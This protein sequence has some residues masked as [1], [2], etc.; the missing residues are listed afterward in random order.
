MEDADIC[1]MA[2]TVEYDRDAALD[3]AM[4]LFWVKGD[5]ATSLKDLENA[6]QMRPGSIYAAFRSKEALF[7]EALDQYATR[8]AADLRKRI[9]AAAS[10]LGALADY[11][12][13]LSDLA[14][15]DR[16]STACMLVKSVLELPAN[17]EIRNVVVAHLGEIE[18]QLVHALGRAVEKSELPANTD[19]ARIAR[20][21]QTY[22]FG[23]KIQAQR[24][25]NADHMRELCGDLAAD[26]RA[27]AA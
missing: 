24:M 16:P 1:P 21:L 5:H 7:N 6:L 20:R 22:I 26:I 13:E 15:C 14:P 23:L 8:M 2:R 4:T 11:I 19:T 3:A 12:N 10:P 27:L 17:T 9:D 18:Q 25:T